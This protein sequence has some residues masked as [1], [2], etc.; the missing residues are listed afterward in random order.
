MATDT[1]TAIEI[2]STG[3]ST[4]EHAHPLISKFLLNVPIVLFFNLSF[5]RISDLCLITLQCLRISLGLLLKHEYFLI[6][7]YPL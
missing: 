6:F 7:L 3:V 1:V 2:D 4:A 5:F